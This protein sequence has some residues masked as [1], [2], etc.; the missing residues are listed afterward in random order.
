M[1][2]LQLDIYRDNCLG[3]FRAEYGIAEMML[4]S[5]DPEEAIR[6][7]ISFLSKAG[8]RAQTVNGAEEGESADDFGRDWHLQRLFD[9]A[10]RNH[11]A[12][13]ITTQDLAETATAWRLATAV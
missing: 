3:V 7:A 12:C 13:L 4:C 2:Y 8:W 1:I 9:E 11:V 5:S 10:E 6:E